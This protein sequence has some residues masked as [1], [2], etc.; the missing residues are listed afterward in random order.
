[1]TCSATILIVG[2]LA[3]LIAASAVVVCEKI[4]ASWKD[5][6]KNDKQQ[7]S[8]EKEEKKEDKKESKKDK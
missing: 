6:K 1:M 7:K 5:K 8:A 4:T 3:V 2:S